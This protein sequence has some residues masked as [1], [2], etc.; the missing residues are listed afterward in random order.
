MKLAQRGVN[1]G[2]LQ[3]EGPRAAFRRFAWIEA[4]LGRLGEQ[5]AQIVAMLNGR[6][7]QV[8][9]LDAIAEARNAERSRGKFAFVSNARAAVG[10][11]AAALQ[12][13]IEDVVV[14]AGKLD[15]FMEAEDFR[16]EQEREQMQQQAAQVAAQ[17]AAGAA[18]GMAQ[19]AL[20]GAPV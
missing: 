4:K 14:S 3:R 2:R 13:K 7:L 17:Q 19:S 20:P 1:L 5:G 11:E 6:D 12:I 15:P 10:D 18:P 8:E 9:T 16:D